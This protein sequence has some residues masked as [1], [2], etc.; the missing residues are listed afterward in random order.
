VL[1]SFVYV[2]AL[3]MMGF[4][5]A[6]VLGASPKYGVIACA[7]LAVACGIGAEIIERREARRLRRKL[8]VSQIIRNT[9]RKHSHESR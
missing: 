3:A 1:K 4:W 9:L 5:F 8:S 6:A 2:L 7:V